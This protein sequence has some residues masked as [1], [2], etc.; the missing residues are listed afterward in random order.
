MN[1]KN[2]ICKSL[3]SLSVLF[4]V[5][6]G[7]DASDLP[8]VQGELIVRFAP[9]PDGKHT[10]K[11]ER[12]AV[13]ASVNGATVKRM[14]KLVS[15]LALVSLP[16]NKSVQDGIADFK[17]TNGIVRAEPNYRMKLA[18]T[19]PN[20]PNFNQLWS[21]RNTFQ[22]G[23]RGGADI[24]ATK[25]WDLKTSASDIVVAVIDSGVDINHE[26]LQGNL[27]VNENEIPGNDT[28]DDD[29]G[30]IDDIYGWHFNNGD[31]NNDLT[32]EHI[33]GTHV[34]GT[35]GAVGN[36]NKGVAGVC[37]NVKLMI[38]RCGDETG[39]PV[40]WD[41][42]NAIAY[43]NKMG[44]KIL[45]STECFIGMDIYEH[46]F[47]Q[48]EIEA[49]DANGLLYVAPA[50]NGG[51]SNPISPAD[52]DCNNI[53]SVMATDANDQRPAWSSY[54]ADDV[55]LAA[56][57]CKIFSTVPG[58]Q[59]ESYGS[60][61][62]WSGTCM[63]TPHVSGACALIWS[64]NP[65]LTHYQVKQIIMD[66]V[67]QIDVLD[68][69]CVTGGRLNV[70]KALLKAT[71]W[72]Q[73]L[74]VADDVDSGDSV[75]PDDF[76]TYTISY[77]NPDSNDPNYIGTITDVNIIDYLPDEIS[78]Y[79]D[80]ITASDGGDYDANTHTVTWQIGTFEPGNSDSV[81][82]TV[83]VTQKAEPEGKLTNVCRLNGDEIR[84][85]TATELTDVNCWNPGT[86]YVAKAAYGSNTG[87]SWQNA[88]TYL[89]SGFERALSDCNSGSEIKVAQGTYYG[90]FDFGTKAITLTSTD[91]NNQ[92]VVENTIIDG[93]VIVSGAVNNYGLE[94]TPITFNDN[95]NSV[96]AGFTITNSEYGIDCNN[97]SITITDCIIKDNK[98]HGI[99]CI[100]NSSA[101]IKN[102]ITKSNGN[103]LSGSG[104]YSD[105]SQ[106]TVSDCNTESNARY[107]IRL[108]SSS[109][110]ILNTLVKNNGCDYAD[111]GGDGI[112]SFESDF[113]IKNCIIEN[114]AAS[115]IYANLNCDN[116]LPAC[117]ITN[118]IFRKNE[119]NGLDLKY[120]TSDFKIKNNWIYKNGGGY[121]DSRPTGYGV[122]IPWAWPPITVRNNSIIENTNCGV[123]L[124]S[125]DNDANI[126]NCI[127]WNNGDKTDDSFGD[128]DYDY[129]TYNC[130]QGGYSGETNISSDPCFVNTIDANNFHL[131]PNSLCIDA[132][133]LNFTPDTNETDIDGESRLFNDRVDMGA[134]EYYLSPADFDG[135]GVVNFVDYAIYAA[136]WQ[137]SLGDPN[138]N[139]ECDLEDNNA[140]DY[141]DLDLFAADWLWPDSSTQSSEMNLGRGMDGGGKFLEQSYSAELAKEAS[142]KPLTPAETI[143]FLEKLWDENQGLRKIIGE[144]KWDNFIDTL[145]ETQ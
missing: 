90:N 48:D 87:M 102:T 60:A 13:L 40:L 75:L 63:T 135:D 11:V 20:D 53:I 136:A 61:G 50:G 131:D 114:N 108:S 7:T 129:V 41:L 122:Y 83:K 65:S 97:S 120:I 133:D 45:N 81:T 105:D 49:A 117:V 121:S 51:S 6:Q 96:I 2:L 140:I 24:G 59:Y 134:D 70:Y 29:N 77:T 128:S 57:G 115:G 107:G 127:I 12:N 78:K 4:V 84:L 69:L 23:G 71:E 88:Y 113:L 118:N 5:V 110:Q 93:T 82:V 10:T 99:N 36:N 42:I 1:T 58:N 8:W 35:L 47:L 143:D 15:G 104:I 66:T 98:D 21:M 56:P 73:I 43:A 112:Y 55:D 111:I 25:A 68:G 33:H 141:N 67:D 100:S 130:I 116:S 124:S 94:D 106:I 137:E 86:I 31:D 92:S 95:P 145:K 18:A 76:V 91:P 101:A 44:A 52:F 125:W 123:V 85:V 62:D 28:D 54:S 17:N 46:T 89:S 32:D 22:I 144:E 142:S 34:A 79:P 132:G 26:D 80:H 38:L 138:Y 64:A 139:D 37:W 74:S 3:L 16:E 39:Y 72:Q 103:Y 30:F 27:W 119:F 14:S 19:L 126:T 9:R 109:A